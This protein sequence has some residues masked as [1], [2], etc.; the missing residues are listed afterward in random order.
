MAGRFVRDNAFLI[1]AAA[2]PVA[3]VALF[4]LAT[5]IPRWTVPPPAY[6]V[7]LRT[8]TFDQANPRVLVE[9]TVRDG[10]LLATLRQ[11]LP[12][13]YPN[14]NTLWVVDHRTMSVREV[15]IDA[16]T[17]VRD[18]ELPTTIVVDALK[19]RRVLDGTKSPDGYEVRQ[20]E[21]RSTGLVGD[22]FGMGRSGRGISL[23]KQGRVVPIEL[24]GTY[25]N[26]SAVF[27]GWL[28][29]GGR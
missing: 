10:K 26:Q 15:S 1:A 19:D 18:D 4:L 7:L 20:P 27:V 29:D 25:Q 2:L 23:R 9:F 22:L 6:D 14:R 12:N 16:A 11:A 17:Q 5:A 24:P 21:Y 3:V 13:V 28:T 8:S